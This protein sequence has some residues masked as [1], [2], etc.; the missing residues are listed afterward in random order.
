VAGPEADAVLLAGWLGGRLG[1]PI[2]LEREPAGELELVEVDGLPAR[3]RR[4]ERRSA[5]ELLSDQLDLF[6]RDAVYEEAVRSFSS[7]RV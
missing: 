7:V 3:P 4:L 1:R 2:E 5:S 6:G